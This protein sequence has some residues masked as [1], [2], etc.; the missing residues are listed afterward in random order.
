MKGWQQNITPVRFTAFAGAHYLTKTTQFEHTSWILMDTTRNDFKYLLGHKI[1][2]TATSLLA[3]SSCFLFLVL[4]RHGSSSGVADPPVSVWAPG[5]TNLGLHHRSETQFHIWQKQ[6]VR[7]WFRW[8]A[9]RSA[10]PG[11]RPTTAT[12][13][14]WATCSSTRPP[15]RH[16][17]REPT[18]ASAQLS[19]RQ[20]LVVF[21]RT[22]STLFK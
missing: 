6:I 5:T 15:P 1:N 2:N 12:A 3:H 18:A 8:R 7:F 22:Q 11:T 17:E 13:R 10:W 19:H 16:G 4:I 21:C 9:G 20:L 14:S